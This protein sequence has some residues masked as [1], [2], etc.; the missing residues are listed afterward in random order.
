M[1]CPAKLHTFSLGSLVVEQSAVKGLI[2]GWSPIW[3]RCH[4][5]HGSVKILTFFLGSSVVEQSLIVGWS[6][7]W[8]R[9]HR[10]HGIANP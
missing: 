4:R 6:P 8:G 5:T 9:C 10:T 7:I 1:I 2:V 3:G